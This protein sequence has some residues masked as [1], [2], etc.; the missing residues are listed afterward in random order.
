M[1][2]FKNSVIFEVSDYFQEFSSY[3][4]TLFEPFSILENRDDGMPPHFQV[5]S[6]L[7]SD[8]D[9]KELVF[10]KI[11]TLTHLF[12]GT[13]RLIASRSPF[14]G[15]KD[16]KNFLVKNVLIDNVPIPLP[17]FDE[18]PFYN[19]VDIG[20]TN[21]YDDNS[22]YLLHKI[23]DRCLMDVDIFNILLISS[24]RFDYIDMYK[25]YEILKK[26]CPKNIL[27][28]YKADL[29]RLT[30]S[31][32]NFTATGFASRHANYDSNP[33]QVRAIQSKFISIDD[34]RELF[35]SIFTNF[36]KIL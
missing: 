25:I 21:N 15:I 12:F 19:F 8:S 26:S 14:G 18:V 6:C 2:E 27:D 33:D 29:D 17:L 34:S 30:C 36:I 24:D 32:N 28:S 3:S 7:I 23:I 4:K 5:Y 22:G 13:L 1:A 11:K 20:K 16:Y 35:K 31:A 9:E 10:S